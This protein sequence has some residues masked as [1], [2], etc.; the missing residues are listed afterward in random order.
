MAAAAM[1][2]PMAVPAP[3]VG[4][5]VAPEAFADAAREAAEA[6]FIVMATVG[7]TAA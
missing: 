1:L 5:M 3:F 6:A 7:G 2:G 4:A